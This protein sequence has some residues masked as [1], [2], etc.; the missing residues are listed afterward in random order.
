MFVCVNTQQSCYHWCHRVCLIEFDT[1]AHNKTHRGKNIAAGGACLEQ[2]NKT[3]FTV[4]SE[5]HTQQTFAC[6]RK[7]IVTHTHPHTHKNTYVLVENYR[8]V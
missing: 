8:D 4:E 5:T 3:Q 1:H 2:Q 7:V 6:M